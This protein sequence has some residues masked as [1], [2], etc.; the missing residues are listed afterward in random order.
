MAYVPPPPGSTEVG[1]PTPDGVRKQDV[2]ITDLPPEVRKSFLLSMVF[3]P[4]LVGA[5]ICVVLFLG[6]I[7]LFKPKEPAQYALELDSPDMRRRWTAAREMSEHISR[8]NEQ[9]N[10][11]IYVPETLSALIKIMENPD[12]DKET[13]AWSPSGSIKQDQEK[14]SI[15]WWAAYTVGHIG[16]KSNVPA[17][18]ERAYQAL[19]KAL[20]EKNTIAIWAAMGLSFMRDARAADTLAKHMEIDPNA[21]VRWAC[22]K[23]LGSIGEYQIQEKKYD[24][25]ER[26]LGYLKEAFQRENAKT[27][28]DEYLIN[29]LA[30]ALA[31][32][33][34][35]TGLPRLRELE[36][37]DDPIVRAIAK[38]ALKI[39]DAGKTKQAK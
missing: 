23:T 39:L 25:A 27:K 13:E 37:H 12:L 1:Q 20:D 5:A 2:H 34:D 10:A 26:I 38:D 4:S 36:L 6:W 16:A 11:R 14:S 31:H 33:N 30:V 17:D 3:F 18:T 22:A 24:A 32:M 8:Y 21:G 9:D 15:R 19:M 28:K 7:A 29:N 35:S